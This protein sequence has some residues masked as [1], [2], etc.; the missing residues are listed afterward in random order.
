M[1]KKAIYYDVTGKHIGDNYYY[2]RFP[3]LV[4]HNYEELKRLINY[5]LYE[6]TD[7]EFNNF[8]NRYVKDEL[9]PYLDSKAISRLQ[10]NAF[11]INFGE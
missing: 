3:N 5:W 7:Q 4:A 2:N 11:R 6:I 1:P 8:L 9:D 10:K